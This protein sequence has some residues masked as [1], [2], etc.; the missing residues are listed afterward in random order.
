LPP[1]KE[2]KA[3]VL[4]FAH[5]QWAFAPRGWNKFNF[6]NQD[7]QGAGLVEQGGDLRTVSG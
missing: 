6:F 7:N 1:G 5:G 3:L 4:A 2:R